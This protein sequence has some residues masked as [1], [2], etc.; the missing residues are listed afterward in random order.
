ML[1]PP[2]PLPGPLGS[3]P[4]RRLSLLISCQPV[5]SSMFVVVEV[6]LQCFHAQ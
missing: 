4:R 5:R 1:A 3:R 2:P 6:L